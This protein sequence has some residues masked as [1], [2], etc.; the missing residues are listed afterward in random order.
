MVAACQAG[1]NVYVEKPIGT[2][3]AE[4]DVMI[5][6][7]KRYNTIVQVGQ[8]QRSGKLWID[9]INY[10]NTGQLGTIGHVHVW[11]NFLYGVLPPPLPDS[12]VPE[13]VNFD[14][15]LGPAPSRSFNTQRFHGAWRMFWDY[16][17]GLI[18][19]WGVHLLDMGLWGMNVKTMPLATTSAGGKFYSPDGAH[20]T[21]DTLSVSYQF[22][23]FLMTWENNCGAESGP[24][25]K[26]YGILFKGTN[27]TLAASREDWQV[28]PEGDKIPAVTVYG[29]SQDHKNHVGNFLE[30]IKTGNR[31]TACTIENGAFCAKYA[32]LGN[33]A[34]RSGRFSLQYDDVKKTFGNAEA[35][36][37]L[38]PRY[39][40]PWKFPD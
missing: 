4:C 7:A 18:T 20:E 14:L 39:R 1:K 11:A 32:Q 40:A 6:A 16:G 24:Y 27:G 21:F 9:M 23:K 29:D 28:Y 26:N 36:Q 8:Q 37:Y 15:W 31:Q 30:C 5:R 10:I 17:G 25:G 2:T 38:K 13:G 35:D 3:V 19:D 22:D 33:I 34:A 12:A